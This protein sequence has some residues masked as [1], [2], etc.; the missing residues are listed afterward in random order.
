MGLR[1]VSVSSRSEE[2]VD[3]VV[4]GVDGT[5]GAG[6]LFSLAV[7]EANFSIQVN[8]D[9]ESFSSGC[10][11]S[12]SPDSTMRAMARAMTETMPTASMMMPLLR[13]RCARSWFPSKLA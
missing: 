13:H 3:V 11:L 6:S 1:N 12:H 9:D 2:A 4:G 5:E 8:G 10:D 7:G